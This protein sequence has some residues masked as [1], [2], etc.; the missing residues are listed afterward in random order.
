MFL[1][2]YKTMLLP[3]QGGSP[4]RIISPGC[5]SAL[6]RAMCPLPLRGAKHKLFIELTLMYID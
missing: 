4:P 2:F 3:L 6:P 1:L 5:R